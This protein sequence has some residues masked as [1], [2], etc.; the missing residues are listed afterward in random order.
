MKRAR[1]H[2]MRMGLAAVALVVA[3]T[4]SFAYDRGSAKPR[5]AMIAEDDAGMG[6]DFIVTGPVKRGVAEPVPAKIS[7]AA[8][9]KPAVR[10]RMRKN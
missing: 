4:A 9:E 8:A 2:W 3:G 1:D 7:T 10:H 6:L 5:D